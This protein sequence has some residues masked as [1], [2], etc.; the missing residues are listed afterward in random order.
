MRDREADVV[1]AE[2]PVAHLMTEID[3]PNP[4]DLLRPGMYAYASIRIERANILSLPASA[5]ATEGNVNEGYQ[6]FC[7]LLENGKVRRTPIKVGSRGDA[8][9]QILKKQVRGDWLDF[10]GAAGSRSGQARLAGR[11]PGGHRR[12]ER[13]RIDADFAPGAVGIESGDG[14]GVA[15]HRT[16]ARASPLRRG[17]RPAGRLVT[18]QSSQLG[19]AFAPA[20]LAPRGHGQIPASTLPLACS[21]LRAAPAWPR[22][23]GPRYRASWMPVAARRIGP[24]GLPARRPRPDSESRSHSRGHGRSAGRGRNRPGPGGGI[25]HEGSRTRGKKPRKLGDFGT[26]GIWYTN[27]FVSGRRPRECPRLRLEIYPTTGI[28]ILS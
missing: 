17:S 4:E 28:R 11:W 23:E 21:Q 8:R 25:P 19:N 2:T 24:L 1:L 18:S 14:H 26:F 3:L 16:H 7:F 5:V 27:C 15:E 10:D 6:D 13:G 20:R 22:A 12:R 9:V